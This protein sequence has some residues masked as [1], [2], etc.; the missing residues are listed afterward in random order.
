MIYTASPLFRITQNKQMEEE[1]PINLV[2][3]I[4]DDEIANFIGKKVIEQTELV[5]QI[6]TFSGGQ[7]AID[8]LNA[9]SNQP[10]LLP[11]IILL[12]LNMPGMD[13]FGFLAEY[14]RLKPRIGKKINIYVLSSSLSLYDHDRIKNIN[15]VSDFVVKP[16]T[17]EKF[18]KIVAALV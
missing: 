14:I 3:L 16:I 12:D 2:A 15:S 1:R 5:K 17:K 13:G 8:F 6:K 9:N 4:D 7:I 11:E 10:D 18:E